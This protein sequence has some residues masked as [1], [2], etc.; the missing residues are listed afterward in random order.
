MTTITPMTTEALADA[1]AEAHLA[2]PERMHADDAGRFLAALAESF[3]D[4]P[5]AAAALLDAARQSCANP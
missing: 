3:D 1:A 4:R 5:G 2:L